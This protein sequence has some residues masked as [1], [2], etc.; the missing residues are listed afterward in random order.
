MLFNNI[1]PKRHFLIPEVVQTSAMDCG[2][3]ALKSLLEGFDI[4][5]SYGRL[6]EVCQT[7]V[8]GTSIDTLEEIANQLGL[9]AEQ[10][11]V[12]MEHLW[13][14]ETQLLPA[15]T[16]VTLPNGLTHFVVLWR[17]H[18]KLIQVMDPGVGRRWLTQTQLTN[19]LLFHTQQVTVEDWYDWASSEDFCVPLR[20]RLEALGITQAGADG[21]VQQ[22]LTKNYWRPLAALDAAIRMVASLIRSKGLYAGE[23]AAKALILLFEQSQAVTFEHS[24]IPASFW[25]AQPVPKDETQLL[26]RGIILVQIAGLRTITEESLEE[27]PLSPELSSVLTD[28]Q[29]KPEQ[30]I[31]QL[32]KK[33]G[34]LL[35]SLVLVAVI[36]SA[37][38]MTVQ[39]LLFKEL[40][41]VAQQ[42][43]FINQHLSVFNALFILICILILL[44]FSMFSAITPMGRRLETWLR[45]AFLEK[46][47]QLGDQYFHSRLTSDMTER[48]YELKLVRTLP[49][50]A[51]Q[52]LSTLFLILFTTI[53]II[54]INPNSFLLAILASG[55]VVGLSFAFQPVLKEQDLR[56]RTHD[57]ALSRF[58]LDA[59]LGLTPVRTHGAE[60]ALRNEYES[61]LVNWMRA[62]WDVGRTNVFVSTVQWG[63]NI[64]LAIWIVFD[65]VAQH[66]EA[67]G[68]L[69]LL[70][71]VMRLPTLGQQ[72]STITQQY[73]ALRNRVLRLLE[74]LTS[75]EESEHWYSQAS[76]K[77]HV[78]TKTAVDI[79]F[80]EVSVQAAGHEILHNLNAHI[81]AGEHIAIVGASGAGK[82]SLVGLLL[83]WYHPMAGQVKVNG[84]LLQAEV[85]KNLRKATAWVDPAV[86]L[87]NRSLRHNLYYGKQKNSITSLDIVLE[88]A[89]LLDILNNL[90]DKLETTLGENG[91][92]VSGGEGQRVRLGRA[93]LRNEVKLVILDE[94]FRGLDR[95]KRQ[96]LL[97]RTRQYWQQAT[98]IFISHDIEESQTFNR[99]WV[100]DKGQIVED[101]Q[102]RI[103][104]QQA[105]SHYN[106][107]VAAEKVVRQTLWESEEWRHLWLEKG[108]LHERN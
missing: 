102:P 62:G 44:N 20:Q 54:W 31:W 71:W 7:S 104:M 80:N 83:G 29:V 105:D 58:Y 9:E 79:H 21:L 50:L 27:V 59:L 23:E 48:A 14:P 43:T 63:I 85:L 64:T 107:L 101:N 81:T 5:V 86:Q 99:V 10:V 42:V 76:E 2:P 97:T 8:D 38:G 39:I 70:F 30:H 94:P 66:G 40:L 34:L 103:L 33:D 51:L 100:M 6:R 95:D 96:R 13:L 55:T 82:S 12:P 84:E 37:L 11:M 35:P 19:D 3:A 46:I 89:E 88:Q 106:Q 78:E 52:F 18:S 98:L 24:P 25:S 93:M 17:K 90:P 73:P 77:A 16:V 36:L 75:P 49:E 26:F 22:A 65:Y 56:F 67:S 4:P 15:I 53:G 57:A 61:L 69:V 74:P 41:D 108:Q 32:L 68:V 45:L 91:G 92:L 28:T 60:Q 87:W 47:P 1:P 72:L